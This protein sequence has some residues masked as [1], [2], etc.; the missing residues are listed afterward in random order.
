[1]SLRSFMFAPGNHARRAEKVFELGADVAIL[2]LEDAVAVAEKAAARASV[3]AALQRPRSCLAYVRINAAD[4]TWCRD[5]IRAVVGPRLDG[6]VLPKAESEAA[7]RLVDTWLAETE[8]STGLTVGALD[9]MP[10]VETALGIERAAEVAAATPR[11]HRLAFGG[12]DYTH[13]LNLIWTEEETELAYARAKLTHASRIAGIEAPID[14]V[15]LQVKEPERFQRS[16]RNGRNMG[17]QGKLC[18]HPDQV[19]LCNAAFMPSAAEVAQAERVVA[20]FAQAEA[21][22]LASIQVDGQ[23]VDYP[24]VNKARRTLALAT[25]AAKSQLERG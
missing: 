5:D 20:A 13:D 8:R 6:I 1:M 11:V 12:G 3:V 14:T 9:L 22:G 10:I 16:A 17:F 19:P 7:L 24:I 15:V 2:D 23:F 18:I 4:T 25:R 21:Q